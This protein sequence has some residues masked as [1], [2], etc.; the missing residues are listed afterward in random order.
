MRCKCRVTMTSRAQ[1]T[2]TETD[3][4]NVATAMTD[5]LVCWGKKGHLPCT[6]SSLEFHCVEYSLKHRQL[7]TALAYWQELIE[8]GITSMTC[9]KGFLTQP[10]QRFGQQGSSTGT[11]LRLQADCAAVAMHLHALAPGLLC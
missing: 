7:P 6:A 8:S 1:P 2:P 9:S 4:E 3:N 11:T 5:A 10:S